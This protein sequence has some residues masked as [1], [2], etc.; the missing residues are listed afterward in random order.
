MKYIAV[1]FII[2]AQSALAIT[3]KGFVTANLSTKNQSLFKNMN[4]SLLKILREV[5]VLSNEHLDHIINEDEASTYAQTCESI[6]QKILPFVTELERL[7][8]DLKNN[9]DYTQLA[10]SS[11]RNI[12]QRLYQ[13]KDLAQRSLEKCSNHEIPWILDQ[14]R[15]ELMNTG[16]VIQQI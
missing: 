16:F 2:L 11:Q 12:D 15:E 13:I 3:N 10:S 4:Y 6:K 1:L 8:K 7:K 14:F 9:S 5:R